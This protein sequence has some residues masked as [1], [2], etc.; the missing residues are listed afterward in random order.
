MEGVA[1]RENDPLL[2]NSGSSS[3]GP[4]EEPCSAHPVEDLTVDESKLAGLCYIGDGQY[5][6][7]NEGKTQ[8]GYQLRRR[9][10]SDLRQQIK[11]A[12]G[13]LS[14]RCGG[15][16]LFVH[17]TEV[18]SRRRVRGASELTLTRQQERL[19]PGLMKPKHF[20]FVASLDGSKTKLDPNYTFADAMTEHCRVLRE[21]QEDHGLE[22][23]A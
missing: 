2:A 17:I 23:R 13:K 9:V 5:P 20:R 11:V 8:D 22:V 14:R 3:R 4:A 6:V 21:S 18:R 1:S 16:S 19:S 12:M 10:E 7:G 15:R